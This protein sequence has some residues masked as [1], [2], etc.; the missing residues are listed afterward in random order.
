MKRIL[1]ILTVAAILWSC[2]NDQ[3]PT[4][5]PSVASFAISSRAQQAAGANEL[6]NDWWVLLVDADG[7]IAATAQGS[8]ASAERQE[9]KVEANTGTYTAY[10]FAN[11]SQSELASA[12]GLSAATF[13]TG[14]TLPADFDIRDINFEAI[15]ATDNDVPMSGRLEDVRITDRVHESFTIEVVRMW[16]KLEFEFSN[17]SNEDIKVLGVS[18]GPLQTGP[19]ALFPAGVPGKPTIL[20]ECT[21]KTSVDIAFD[22][23][24]ISSGSEDKCLRHIYI[25]ESV[26]DSHPTGKFHFSVR[27][28]RGGQPQEELYALTEDLT[29]INRNDYIQIPIDFIDWSL[30]FEC[31]FAPPIGGYP[32]VLIEVVNH[33][34]YIKF[35]SSGRFTLTPLVRKGAEGDYLA[36]DR[37]EYTIVNISD[38]QAIL[39]GDLK[40][41]DGLIVGNLSDKSNSDGSPRQGTASIEVNVRVKEAA[42]GLD[43]VF[44]RKFYIIRQKK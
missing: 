3:G 10:A 40:L 21:T 4:A 6:I 16:G 14:A 35:G 33:E 34:Y 7:H 19:I 15:M 12:L 23:A 26:S 18:F 44:N 17:S 39:D 1:Y 22:G 41:E 42:N 29:W 8:A 2:N 38:P 36:S 5:L 28:Q 24:D 30:R 27:L 25:H 9:F 37:L 43:H 13:D 11:I 31:K 20:D 32:A